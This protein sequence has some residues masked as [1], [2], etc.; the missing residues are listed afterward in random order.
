MPSKACK[1]LSAIGVQRPTPTE[2]EVELAFKKV[3]DGLER[4]FNIKDFDS[5]FKISD[6]V[7]FSKS[8]DKPVLSD[9][10]GIACRDDIYFSQALKELAKQATVE[11]LTLTP[12]AIS[13]LGK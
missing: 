2:E 12:L 4:F 1:P 13:Y 6:R 11:D 7:P 8:N 5:R 3:C 9:A 10:M